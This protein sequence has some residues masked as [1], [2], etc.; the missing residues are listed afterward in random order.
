METE[1]SV[2]TASCCQKKRISVK[3]TELND[4]EQTNSR[5]SILPGKLLC[6][7]DHARSTDPTV[8]FLI[9]QHIKTTHYKLFTYIISF[10][11]Y[12]YQHLFV[13]TQNVYLDKYSRKSTQKT[14]TQDESKQ[15]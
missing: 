3:M 14:K 15:T 8:V 7:T 10:I 6:C 2:K 4:E 12:I 13:L 9:K 1:N 11:L 5:Y